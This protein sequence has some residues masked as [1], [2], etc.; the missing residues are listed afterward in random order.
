LKISSK[1]RKT[2][3]AGHPEALCSEKLPWRQPIPISGPQQTQAMTVKTQS[4]DPR[5]DAAAKRELQ[6]AF[7]GREAVQLN[8]DGIAAG[9]GGIHCTTQQE[10]K[11]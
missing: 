6:K 3:V 5:T 10:P 11:V 2:L 4:L 8:I 7:P 1:R 9:V